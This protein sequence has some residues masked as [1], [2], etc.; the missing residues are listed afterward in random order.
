VHEVPSSSHTHTHT[1]S[2]DPSVELEHTTRSSFIH[3]FCR[4]PRVTRSL[5]T[6]RQA[7]PPPRPPSR[8]VS[9]WRGRWQSTRHTWSAGAA[10]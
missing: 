5:L 4:M 6:W 10:L 2:T 7:A 3:S 1:P 8:C 9:C